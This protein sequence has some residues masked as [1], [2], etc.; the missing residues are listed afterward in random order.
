[1]PSILDRFK[2]SW[3]AFKGRDPTFYKN[4]GPSYYNRP[5][6]Y[7][8]RNNNLKSIVNTIFNQIAVDAAQ[9]DIKHVRLNSDGDYKA[10]I[11]STLNNIFTVEANIDQTGRAF[12]KDI[13]M[14]MCDEGCVALVPVTTESNLDMTGAPKILEARVGKITAWYS[15]HIR[16][17]VYNEKICQKQEIIIEKDKCPIIENPF[18]TIMNEPNS[19]AQ[20]LLVVLNQLDRTNEN[21]SA[22]K[23]DLLVQL[24][25]TLK[26]NARQQQAKERKKMLEEQL[27]NSQY[28]IGY[29]DAT[30]KVIQLNRSVENNL[31]EQA[32]EL[33]LQ[34]Y[35][36]LG[37]SEKILDGTADEATM[38][39]YYNRTI[40]P[41][42]TTIV[43]EITRKWI[44]K[45][46]RT[47]LQ[48]VKFFRDPFKLVP[49]AQLA[50]ISDKFTR[51][52][53]MTSN[54]I[55]SKIGL[56]PSED[57]RANE[58]RNSNL[59]HP[60]EKQEVENSK[61]NNTSDNDIENILNNM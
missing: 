32:K 40:E 52:E 21:N 30:E 7:R 57:P 25:Y 35:N 50:E 17:E 6:R 54:E 15:E 19:I 9:C 45:T 4:I 13:V 41:I 49:V 22:G 24:P 26:G 12:V 2:N 34:F 18:Y 23:I 28:G 58:L 14:S 29:I 60:D 38:I 10:T 16:V 55:R 8:L 5:D 3:D 42:L 31:W 44:T 36:Q 11:D 48:A 43:E 51:N 59:N 27:T 61:S 53:I 39:N 46:G 20:R 33:L 37:F 1:M 56:R 47:Q